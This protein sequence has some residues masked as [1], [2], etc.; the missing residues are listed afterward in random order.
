MTRYFMEI[1]SG[2]VPFFEV[3]LEMTVVLRVTMGER[4]LRP[5]ICEPRKQSCESVGLNDEVWNVVD[6]C[7][8]P[9]PEDRLSASDVIKLLSPMV[10]QP[11]VYD[12]EGYGTEP[13]SW[14]HFLGQH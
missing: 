9:N 6:K 3:T 13:P 12:S 14:R 4:P 5:S 10:L 2:Q 1:F 8:S 7:W 11:P